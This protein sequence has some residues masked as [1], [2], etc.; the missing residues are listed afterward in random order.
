MHRQ[1]I[2]SELDG[3]SE[4]KLAS[5]YALIHH[6]KLGFYKERSAVAFLKPC[7]KGN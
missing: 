5:L 4:D 7:Q 6:F 2:M 1:Q 3:I